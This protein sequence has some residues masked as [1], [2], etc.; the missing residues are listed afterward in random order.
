[1][2]LDIVVL[3]T[4]C[5]CVV[6][7]YELVGLLEDEFPPLTIAASRALLGALA[8]FLFCLLTRQPLVPAFRRSAQLALIGVVGV[9][10][11]WAMGSLGERSVDPELTMLL[12][13]VVPITTL[14]ITALPPEPQRIWWPAWIGTA[15]AT[16]GLVVGIGPARRVDEPSALQAVLMITFGFASFAL[17]AVL[18]ESRTR[19]LSPVPVGGVTMLHAAIF[20]WALAFLL[21]PPVQV[22]ASTAGWLRLIALG[23]AGSAIP[24]ILL[25]VLVQRAGAEFLSLYGYLLP[26]L[27]TL[28]GWLAFGRTPDSAFLVGVPITLA[29]VAA[30][31]WARRRSEA[32]SPEPR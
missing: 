22:Q 25:F 20:L 24:V 8:I 13:C 2:K 30:V 23:V 21:E 9:G 19:G 7:G 17:S 32:A 4:Y 11:L 1:M 15:V 10:T 31:Q 26:L 6:L 18:A 29:G 12:V 14:V 28:A 16:L 5:G 27:G 3:L